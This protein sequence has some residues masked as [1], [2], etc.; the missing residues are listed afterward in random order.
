MLTGNLATDF[1]SV[2]GLSTDKTHNQIISEEEG[3]VWARGSRGFYPYLLSPRHGSNGVHLTV[4]RRH[5]M[6]DGLGTRCP[7]QRLTPVIYFK[8][9]SQI[10]RF[11]WSPGTTSPSETQQAQTGHVTSKL[12]HVTSNTPEPLWVTCATFTVHKV[13]LLCS[14]SASTRLTLGVQHSN[15][16][17]TMYLILTLILS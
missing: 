6:G 14:V 9:M 13:V 10:L 2:T 5:R 12:Q 17:W 1:C 15:L 7:L 11:P 3:C 16:P 4:H 8:A